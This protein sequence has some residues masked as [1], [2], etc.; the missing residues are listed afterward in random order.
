MLGQARLDMENKRLSVPALDSRNHLVSLELEPFTS[1][2][3]SRYSVY[4]PIAPNDDV[5][6]RRQE[7]AQADAEQMRH[8]SA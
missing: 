3:E 7:L 1:I 8:E 2:H 6:G 5:D 4:L